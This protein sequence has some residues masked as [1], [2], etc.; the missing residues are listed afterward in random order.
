MITNKN[1]NE[2]ETSGMEVTKKFQI[3]AS[4]K[5]FSI[6]SSNLYSRKIHAI[7]R[8][9]GCNALDAHKMAGCPEKQFDVFLPT[10]FDQKFY[11]RDYGTGIS[12]EDMEKV[13]TVIFESTKD[14]SND[15]IGCL[16]LGSKTPLSY[17]SNFIVKSYQDGVA[18]TYNIFLDKEGCPS[19]TKVA[20]VETDEEN[21]LKV[22]FSVNPSDIWKFETAASDIY[23]WFDVKPNLVGKEIV[24]PENFYEAIHSGENYEITKEGNDSCLVM[25]NIAYPLRQY[26][27][28]INDSKDECHE[29]V[30]N[31]LNYYN[32]IG[33]VA[34]GWFDIA[35]SR[36]EMSLDET[37]I[38]NITKF[39]YT[40]ALDYKKVWMKGLEEIF[41]EDSY[42]KACC[43]F[44][45]Y[46]DT[47]QKIFPDLTKECIHV[48][49]G[50]E[51]TTKIYIDDTEK[52][53]EIISY[54]VSRRN[55]GKYVVTK[56]FTGELFPRYVEKGTHELFYVDKDTKNIVSRVRNYLL[57]KE[58]TY[59]N[60]NFRVFII[61]EKGLD[62]FIE[63]YDI[64][65]EYFRNLSELPVPT[66]NNSASNYNY[67]IGRVTKDSVR[68]DVVSFEDGCEADSI[69]YKEDEN[70]FFFRNDQ[71]SINLGMNGIIHGGV[72]SPNITYSKKEICELMG[73]SYE[74]D[75]C[76]FIHLKTDS[77]FNKVKKWDCDWIDIEEEIQ[78]YFLQD[79]KNILRKD[80]FG[81]F[82]RE[83]KGG[84]SSLNVEV[85]DI[86][87]VY[88]SDKIELFLDT[89]RKIEKSIDVPEFFK[90]CRFVELSMYHGYNQSPTFLKQYKIL[91]S[92]FDNWQVLWKT[93]LEDNSDALKKANDELNAEVDVIFNK[94]IDRVKNLHGRE[95]IYKDLL[96]EIENLWNPPQIFE[97]GE[98][99]N[100][101]SEENE[102]ELLTECA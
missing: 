60:N 23:K 80:F 45:N 89:L 21:G 30:K 40:C 88:E 75:N 58:I 44:V 49:S 25:G 31:F 28:E 62:T 27:N 38:E 33:R 41:N 14:Q 69:L 100:E 96:E 64:P 15:E 2:I 77:S 97:E 10:T 24:I 18:K 91:K 85:E 57:G 79:Y 52:E 20:E 7:L 48:K 99:E 78:S 56:N 71:I 61:S 102:K 36:E 63:D 73:F 53:Y 35:P 43:K 95:S 29:V 70:V 94:I 76:K 67:K 3:K 51:L 55:R 81:K 54:S 83:M 59:D 19:Y 93:H 6:L 42:F 9:L 98:E 101:E 68:G 37:S 22:Q 26:T 90:K 82:I 1:V 46:P 17:T 92:H 39:L 34:I 4:G 66:R 16:G 47:M 8:E 11:V 12:E 74:D 86:K 72:S 87:A 13:Y 84:I 5:A 65:E 50:K 32:I